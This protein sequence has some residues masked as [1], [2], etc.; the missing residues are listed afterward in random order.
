MSTDQIMIFTLIAATLG[1]FIWGRWRVDVIALGALLAGVL[2]GLV[3][4]SEAFDGFGHPA[5]ITVAAVL[6]LSAG[7][8]QSGLVDI[9]AQRAAARVK[10]HFVQISVICAIGAALSA[11]MNNVGAL[12]LLMPVAILVA[13]RSGYSPSLVLMPLSFA[14]I[15]GGLTT[16]IGTPPNIIIAGFR[17]SATGQ[18]FEMFDFAGAGL[19][20]AL[21]GVVFLI[22]LG[23]RLIPQREGAV[24]S[25]KLFEIAGYVTELHVLENGEADGKRVQDIAEMMDAP[26]ILVALIRENKRIVRRLRRA[27][28][29]A[30][31]SLLVQ[32]DTNQ[33]EFL[34]AHGFEMAAQKDLTFR[35][36][37]SERGGFALN[38]MEAVVRPRSWIEGRTPSL[39]TLRSRYGVNLLGIARQGAPVRSRLRDVRFQAGDVLLLQG[40]PDRLAETVSELGCLPLARRRL[41]IIGQRAFAPF[42]IFAGGVALAA[43]GILPAAIALV[44]AALV[45][46]LAGG[47]H[48]RDAYR[49]IDWQVI[50]LL[51]AMIPVGAA[52]EATGAAALL[53]GLVAEFAGM[54]TPHLV[55]AALLITTMALTAVMNNAATALIMAPIAAQV[56]SG[57]G[58]ALDPMLMTVAIGASSAFITPIG[59]QN[60]LLVMGP[61]GYHFGDYWRLGLPL[62]V[63]IAVM[64]LIFV[65]MVW[66]F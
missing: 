33:I 60:N 25:E 29:Q 41:R 16:L 56:A 44:L 53:A 48:I 20:I 19:P 14:T 40:E 28:L 50:I 45:M 34:L 6:A 42:A 38:L 30:G 11:F 52:M 55:M 4:S 57:M 39:L 13:S 1:L 46:T 18:G 24:D 5:V 15:L 2:L 32:A 54:A 49:A 64:T 27:R 58:V 7:L 35:H 62:Q 43:F 37:R 36:A 8:S 23:W 17:Q 3:P 51:G 63:L 65:P 22:I 31:D 10:G 21:A 9:M 61:G 26:P 47:L 66:Q 59:H 12:A